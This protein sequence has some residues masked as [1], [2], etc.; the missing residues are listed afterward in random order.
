MLV[1]FVV[2]RFVGVR[3]T[4]ASFVMSVVITIGLNV[5]LSYYHDFRARRGP[6]RAPR[7]GGDIR[8]RDEDP[9]DGRPGGGRMTPWDQRD[10]QPRGYDPRDDQEAHRYG[11][12]GRRR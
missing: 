3:S 7:S 1:L 9:A 5:G 11:D 8:W 2:L 4:L 10:Y 6:S 12:E